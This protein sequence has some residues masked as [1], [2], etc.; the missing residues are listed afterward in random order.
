MKKYLF[1]ILLLSVAANSQEFTGSWKVISYEDGIVYLNKI[2]NSFSYT[3]PSRKEDT[4]S[5]QDLAESLIFPITYDFNN[6]GT[7]NIGHPV[8]GKTKGHFEIDIQ[9]KKIILTDENGQKE[10]VP[11]TYRNE[12]LYVK[13]KMVAVYVEFGL[14]KDN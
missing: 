10:E 13:A 4:K 7:Y 9:G 1:L 8:L 2:T 3:D 14:K 6:D 5:L 12:I 11:F